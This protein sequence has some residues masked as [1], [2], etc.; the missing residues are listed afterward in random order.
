MT[1]RVFGVATAA[2]ATATVLAGPAP[3]QAAEYTRPCA[4]IPAKTANVVVLGDSTGN[5]RYEWP[6]LTAVRLSQKFPAATVRYSIWGPA[7]GRYLPSVVVRRG[8]GSVTMHVWNASAPGKSTAY[9]AARLGS[10]L[11]KAAT[12]VLVS[13]GHNEDVGQPG[14][15]AVRWRQQYETLT[16]RVRAARPGARICAVLQN[17]QLLTSVQAERNAVYRQVAAGRGYGVTDVHAV[18]TGRVGWQAGWMADNKHPNAAGQKAWA[19]RVQTQI[20][21]GR[22]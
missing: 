18:F 1:R 7:S 15:D 8:S 21:D 20:I 17:P 14:P 3:V 13:H 10:M 6:Y 4:R 5:E 12:L 16:S 11:P 22:P 19:A 9:H 2:L